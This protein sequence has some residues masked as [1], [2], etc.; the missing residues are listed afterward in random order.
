VLEW[1]RRW[2][3]RE[4]WQQEDPTFDFSRD[5]TQDRILTPRQLMDGFAAAILGQAHE[6]H[7][8]AQTVLGKVSSN[9]GGRGIKVFAMD[10]EPTI[11]RALGWMIAAGRKWG[12]F[13][14]HHWMDGPRE[15]DNKGYWARHH[16]VLALWRIADQTPD[17]VSQ[18]DL[19]RGPVAQRRFEA[20]VEKMTDPAMRNRLTN[21]AGQ[22]VENA[23]STI[24]AWNRAHPDRQVPARGRNASARFRDLVRMEADKLRS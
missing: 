7:G 11:Y 8:R 20:L 5:D 23:E 1:E 12:R 18:A 19:M 24:P 4:L 6:A 17:A 10:Q 3:E 15:P 16:F 22:A 21:L 2:N 14:R 9:G 13:A